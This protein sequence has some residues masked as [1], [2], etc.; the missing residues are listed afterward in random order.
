MKKSF[1]LIYLILCASAAPVLTLAGDIDPNLESVLNSSSADE[2]ISVLVYLDDRVD[3]KAISEQIDIQKATL[4]YRHEIVVR[5]LQ[6]K[7]EQSQSEIIAYLSDLKEENK[8]DDFHSYWIAN[9]VRVDAPANEIRNIANHPNVEKVYFNYE[10]EL[11]EPVDVTYDTR[12]DITSIEIG[13]EAV[14]APEVWELGFDGSGVLV[15]NM[16]TGVEGDHPA[17][18]DNWAGVADPRYEGHPEWAW[19]DPYNNQNDFPYDDG[20]H[21]THTM[22]SVC[23]ASPT[24]GDTVG[25]APG[26]YWM[27]S[28]PIDRG[29][30]IPRTVSDAILSFEWMTDPDGDPTTNWDVPA[31]CSNSWGVTTGHGYPPCDETFWSY[32]DACEAAGTVI[33]FSAG[34]EGFSG[35]RRPSDRAT[36]DYR[37]CA[38][39]A[40]DA[41]NSNWP[42][43]SFSSRGPTNCTPDGSAA[44]KP[45]IAAPGVNVRSS[46]P[47]G[48]YTSMSG[49]SMASP[50]VNGVV[51]LMRDANPNLS[52]ELIK[53][54]IYDTAYD[55]GDPDEDNDYGWGMIDAYEAVQ[56][57][58]SYLEGYG[59]IAGRL[60]DSESGAGLAGTISVTN[61]TPQIVTNCNSEGYYS[62]AV[63][64]DSVWELRAEY[65]ED[66][67]PSF[68]SVSTPEN[69]TTYQD[70][71]LDSNVDIILRAS[72][73]NPEDIA[74]RT[75]YCR[76]S[77]D[78][79]GF[80]DPEWNCPFAPMKDDGIFPDE[81]AGDGIFTGLVKLAADLSNT[82]SWAVYSENYNDDAS[83]LQ[84]GDDFDI[85]DPENPPNIPVLSVNP[86][87]SE[88]DWVLTVYD[89]DDFVVELIPGYEGTAYKWAG[90]GTM[91]S[92]T[93][94][95]F[96]I[97]PMHSLVASYGEGGV[98]AP[99]FVI[100][101]N[102]TGDYSFIFNDNTDV[103]IID[104]AY[105]S[106]GNLTAT[107]DMD[108]VVELNWEAP[109][110]DPE[111][112]NIY[113]SNE[114]TGPFELIGNVPYTELTYLDESVENYHDYY[115]Y[116]TAVY[117][118]GI[119]SIRSNIAHGYAIT[120]ARLSVSPEHIDIYV[121]SGY[122][123]QA[124][125]Y[126]SNTGDLNLTY[127]I[128]AIQDEEGLFLS[129]GQNNPAEYYFH[130]PQNEKTFISYGPQNPPQILDNGG[131]DEFG[132]AWVDSDDPGGPEFN[133]IDISG[134][135]SLIDFGSNIDDGNSGPLDLGFTFG[136]YGN[137]FTSINVCTN[138][139]A[140]FT[141]GSSVEYGNMPIPDAEPPNNMLAV[142]YDDM[143][144]ENGG[145]AYIYTNNADTA[146]ITWDHVADWREEGIFNFQIVLIAPNKIFYQY[147]E[148][149][150][151]RL[152]E[153]TIGIEDEDGAVGL[154]VANDQV[155]MHDN[156]AIRFFKSWLRVDP[157]S[158]DVEPEQTDTVLVTCDASNMGAG[159]YSGYLIVNGYDIYHSEEPE[160]ITVTM[161]VTQTDVPHDISS[162]LPMTYALHQN[163][164]N[165]FNPST[166][167]KYDL[168]EACH[169][170]L[171]IYNLLGQK[172][173]TIVDKYQQAGYKSVDWN[174][175]AYSSGVYFY[176]LATGDKSFT[177]RMTLLK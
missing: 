95:T 68:A 96:R 157:S 172:L 126:I 145:N 152:A 75:F 153:C 177:K 136:F 38:V 24:T 164:P 58:L 65:N 18:V 6:E 52:V 46:Y 94:Y 116:T 169:V 107:L 42:I 106:P 138:G 133:W 134:I 2:N 135:G 8:I 161:Y 139:W 155:Y 19:Y 143:N 69:D 73:G 77:W 137:E 160:T 120:G 3:L 67:L 112:Y 89:Q 83:R 118:G 109:R 163:Y 40:V 60:T 47:G 114:E 170:E 151:G 101:P 25:V 97:Y 32:L 29:G 16:D 173:S 129:P 130:R 174:A 76:G 110:I 175:S 115:Y 70:F 22:G 100:T 154:Q 148:M 105:P 72:F 10:I 43:A 104:S 15:A 144:L 37:T 1:L 30:G 53:Q 165:P 35:L 141:D 27:A 86:S 132:Y 20:G 140:S 146:I 12:N 156:L 45:D 5:A 99:D 11:I 111:T 64:S 150:P 124:D 92:G 171:N 176:K 90:D 13:V 49:T 159:E 39:A 26:A 88:G 103:L 142:F 98:G 158:D 82:Y 149:G 93:T 117:T 31:V 166:K 21:G 4:R 87:G 61:R 48:V 102:Y 17:L 34:N 44:I 74:Y 79:D 167:I 147:E 51:A 127:E 50:H 57:A 59:T 71:A 125:L 80:Y 54:I 62:M 123:D 63:P 36:D 55:L 14:R 84:D 85:T 28:A 78:A 128:F 122:E 113:R 131:P 81:A 162:N 56:V 108:M 91:N 33:L 23:G 7:A 119:E 9:A 121:E 168:P 41:N 66:Y